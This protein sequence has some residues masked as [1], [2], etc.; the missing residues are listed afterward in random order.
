MS[1]NKKVSF[2]VPLRYLFMG[3]PTSTVCSNS[4]HL[5]LF[6]RRVSRRECGI[7]F[8]PILLLLLPFASIDLPLPISPS[9]TQNSPPTTP[10]PTTPTTTSPLPITPTATTPAPFTPT[11]TPSTKTAPPL[12]APIPTAS[13]PIT[14]VQIWWLPVTPRPTPRPAPRPAP[15]ADSPSLH[16]T[17]PEA[18]YPSFSPLPVSPIRRGDSILRC[19]LVQVGVDLG[20]GSVEGA[21]V[22]VIVLDNA[23]FFH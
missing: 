6:Q 16:P 21:G 8:L 14:P 7:R 23:Y 15:R 17:H 18:G 19:G 4:I 12:I 9:S 1:E 11:T 2:D 13:R 22:M 20:I 3:H 5:L 10:T